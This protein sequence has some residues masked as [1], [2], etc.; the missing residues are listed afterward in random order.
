MD[1]YR[2]ESNWE[3]ALDKQAVRLVRVDPKSGLASA[4]RQSFG[5]KI[6]YQD[7]LSVLFDKK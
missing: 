2:A 7:Q 1:T 3:E 5:W 6:V 4:L